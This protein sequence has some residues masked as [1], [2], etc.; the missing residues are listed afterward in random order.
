MSATPVVPQPMGNVV[1]PPEVLP[2]LPQNPAPVAQQLAPPGQK[3]ILVADTTTTEVQPVPIQPTEP[4]KSTV[5]TIQA[6]LESEKPN[7]ELK[8]AQAAANKLQWI[9]ESAMVCLLEQRL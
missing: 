4:A 1:P 9:V 7:A 3:W 5:E 6:E 8:V 2:K